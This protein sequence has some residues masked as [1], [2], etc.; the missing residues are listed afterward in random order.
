MFHKDE[1]IGVAETTIEQ[2]KVG[3]RNAIES[4]GVSSKGVETFF[5][6]I[7]VEDVKMT[8]R[9]PSWVQTVLEK[10]SKATMEAAGGAANKWLSFLNQDSQRQIKSEELRPQGLLYVQF[11]IAPAKDLAKT[12]PQVMPPAKLDLASIRAKPRRTNAEWDSG[13]QAPDRMFRILSLDGGGVRGILTAGILRRLV[14]EHRFPRLLE[15]ADLIAGTST[16]GILALL[17]AAGYSPAEAQRLYMYHCPK[18]FTTSPARR[19]SPFTA[20]Y[21]NEPLHSMLHAYFQD[22]RVDELPTPVMVTAFKIRSDPNK[23][24]T[25]FFKQHG[26][27]WRPALFTNVKRFSGEVEPDTALVSDVACRTSAAPT[28]FPTYQG[29]VDGAIFANNPSLSAIAKATSHYRHVK[30]ARHRIAVLSV[31]AG[32]FD[33]FIPENENGVGMDWGLRQWAPYLR[34]ILLDSS[35]ISLETNMALLMG[36]GYHR[37][38]PRL[39]HD[40][41][42]DDFVSMNDLLKVSRTCDLAPTEEWIKRVW[43]RKFDPLDYV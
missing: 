34:S 22:L 37:V 5:H 42:L 9:K 17:F 16:G 14:K 24:E 7:P 28:Y 25:T 6:L 31:G 13:L 33:Y 11:K 8:G 43:Y 10:T 2:V 39:P 15:D 35:A 40:V 3:Q 36:E 23:H 41:D 19:Y 26:K 4:R 21:N 38:N 1:L 20:K 18:I 27:S 29:Y 30:Q 12:L 32:A